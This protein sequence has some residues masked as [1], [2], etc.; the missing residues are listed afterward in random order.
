MLLLYEIAHYDAVDGGSGQYVFDKGSMHVLL[1]ECYG[2][3][4]IA[5]IVL[6]MPQAIAYHSTLTAVFFL[7]P[8]LFT[9]GYPLTFTIHSFFLHPPL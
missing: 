6:S 2:A 3:L 8:V 5:T 7:L 1:A 4:I 9:R